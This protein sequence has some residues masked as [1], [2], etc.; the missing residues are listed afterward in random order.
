MHHNLNKES[1]VCRGYLSDKDYLK[2]IIPHH[3]VAIDIS[4][5]LQKRLKIQEC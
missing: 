2:H 4:I 5:L 1:N 3:Q